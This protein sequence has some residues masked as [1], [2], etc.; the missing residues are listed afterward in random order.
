MAGVRDRLKHAW[1]AFSGQEENV[2]P[3]GTGFRYGPSTGLRPDRPQIR[4]SSEKTIITPIYN[5]MAMDISAVDMK[6]V[7]VDEN[8]NFLSEVKSGLNECLQVEANLDQ[9]ASAFLQDI[10]MTLFDKGVAAIV[11]V[12]TTLNP[13][14]TGGY[15]VKS[16]RVGD[17][18]A[19][20]PKH[21]R[22]SLYNEDKGMREDITLEKSFV[23]IVENPLYAV[24]NE[25]NST[26]KRLINKLN[27]LDTVDQESSSGKLNMI[28]Q[29]PYVIKSEARRT[30]AEQRRSDIE[31][32][33]SSNKYGIAYTDG[34]EKITQL[35]RP[36]ENDFKSSLVQ[37]VESAT[38]TLYS[39]LGLT[40]EI[41]NG[42]A[43]EQAMLN[44]QNRTIK[45]IL[46]AITESMTRTFLTKTA[47]AQGQ[48][49][50]FIRSPFELVPINNIAEIA[51]KFTR[52]EILSANEIRGIV[53]FR[54]SG[55]PKANE[56]VNS[57]MPQ[58][59]TETPADDTTNEVLDDLEKTM[60]ELFSD[61]GVDGG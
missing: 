21:V 8:E 16:L 20:Y 42:T 41:M 36:L 37:Q 61:L 1:N 13:N 24:M 5:R 39:Q 26:L 45:P 47:R 56:L 12:D 25:P 35:N 17:I 55:D 43:D 60:D 11:P 34:T 33:L 59:P 14:E 32:Q 23:A 49:V 54:P 57:N 10:A 58:P 53:G 28:I 31:F 48:S 3:L 2:D 52:N 30:Q 22:I 15:D 29:L 51:D 27:L 7:R 38:K 50:V 19:W 9:A 6:H 44:Y 40:E 4:L 46:R 18:V